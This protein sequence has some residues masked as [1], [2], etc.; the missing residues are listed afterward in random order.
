MILALL[1]ACGGR[2][3]APTAPA[4]Q[5]DSMPGKAA[6][7]AHPRLWLTPADVERHPVCGTCLIFGITP[8]PT[9]SERDSGQI[10]AVEDGQEGSARSSRPAGLVFAHRIPGKS[11]LMHGAGRCRLAGVLPAASLWQASRRLT[12]VPVQSHAS[13][14]RAGHSM[15]TLARSCARP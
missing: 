13:T 2:K 14:C 9:R 8:W 6:G 10:Q 12:T 11:G 15:A 7:G 5:A 3:A 1:A 4:A